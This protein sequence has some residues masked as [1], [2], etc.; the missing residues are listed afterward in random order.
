MRLFGKRKG[1]L[2]GREKVTQP[3][4][5]VATGCAYCDLCCLHR[6]GFFSTFSTS[7]RLGC[8]GR[9]RVVSTTFALHRGHSFGRGRMHAASEGLT[10]DS[11]STRDEKGTEASSSHA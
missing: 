7:T 5:L 11:S 8:S 2:R 6:A 1:Q 3:A 4:R 10:P 9:T